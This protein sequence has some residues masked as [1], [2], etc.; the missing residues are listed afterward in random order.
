MKLSKIAEIYDKTFRQK[1]LG[2]PIYIISSRQNKGYIHIIDDKKNDDLVDALTKIL[3]G[4]K[5]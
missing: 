3:D 5:R 2:H 1:L 4:I